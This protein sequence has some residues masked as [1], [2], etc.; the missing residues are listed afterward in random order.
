MT[1][2]TCTLKTAICGHLYKISPENDHGHL[3]SLV[4][5]LVAG[6]PCIIRTDLSLIIDTGIIKDF[7]IIKLLLDIQLNTKYNFA[8]VKEDAL[9]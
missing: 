5:Q 8:H 7:E 1:T 4:A 3:W 6:H 9:L 2:I